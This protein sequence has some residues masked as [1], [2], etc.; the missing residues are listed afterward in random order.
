MLNTIKNYCDVEKFIDTA[1]NM[2]EKY[3]WQK[4]VVYP[5]SFPVKVTKIISDL[6]DFDSCTRGSQEY[7]ISLAN[8]LAPIMNEWEEREQEEKID[9]RIKKSG[10]II[11]LSPDMVII[12]GDLVEV[13]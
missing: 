2:I 8:G 1:E 4:K 3:G 10:K 9:C 11:R 7:L 5:Y 13:L 12:F 6:K